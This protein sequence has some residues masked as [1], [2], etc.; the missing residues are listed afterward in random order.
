MSG[1]SIIL[2]GGGT[3]GH[4]SPGIAIAE[5]IAELDPRI[6]RVFACST[7]AVDARMLEHVHADFQPIEAEGLSLS[8]R[9]LLRFAKAFHA[10]RAAAS[11][12]LV[13]RNTKVVIALGGFVTG[14]VVM[15]ARMRKIPVLLVNLDATPGKANRWVA[16]GA[17]RILTAC[18]TPTMPRFAE[19]IVG[20]PIRRVAIAQQSVAECR[21]RLSLEPG[22]HTLFVTGA[23]QGAAS[24]NDLMRLLVRRDRAAFGGWQVLHLVGQSDRTPM[25]LAYREAGVRASV[26]PF[27]HEMGCAWGASDLALSRAGAN[28][29]A[30]A[31]QNAVPTVFAPYPYH[32]DLHQKWNAQPFHEQKLAVLCEDLIDA[33]R[34]HATLGAS[35]IDLMTNHARR[36]TMRAALAAQPKTDAALDIAQTALSMIA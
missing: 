24:L 32:K 30:E 7:R 21:A 12:L 36:E 13:A 26:V 29:V 16:R 31:V 9:K 5:R 18:A 8:P 3:G 23:S 2:A 1:A 27:L 14:P 19:R 6:A 33:E 20:M 15:A 4:I 35:L 28:S 17:S 22:L 10:G 25:E 11:E 34:N